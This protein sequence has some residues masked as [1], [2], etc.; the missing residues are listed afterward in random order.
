MT[1]NSE[2]MNSKEIQKQANALVTEMLDKGL[3][4]PDAHV[5]IK[6]NAQPYVYLVWKDARR[7][8]GEEYR[9]IR[10]D[11]VSGAIQ[12]ARDFIAK[13]P[14][15]EQRKLEEFMGALGKVIDLGKQNGIEADYLNPLAASMKKLSE[16]IITDQRDAS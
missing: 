3:R 6:A 14:D 10:V 8:F 5:T 1:T 13:I 12:G 16:N 15:A 7:Q 4:A 11:S 2:T 9:S